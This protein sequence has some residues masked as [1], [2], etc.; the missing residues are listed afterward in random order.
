MDRMFLL[1]ALLIAVAALTP[2][3]CQTVPAVVPALAVGGQG[4]LP[5]VL[6]VPTD[7]AAP[8]GFVVLAKTA[9]TNVTG[10]IVSGGNVGLSP[11]SASYLTGF[12][13]VADDSGA[14]ATSAAVES[15]G[16]VFAA[17]NAAPT[18]GALT[19]AILAMEAAYADAA[20]RSPPD[21][22]N[23]GGGALGG[24]TLAPGLYTW[25][26]SVAIARDLTLAGGADDVWIL[27][28]AGDLTLAPHLRVL[29]SGGARARNVYWQVA[30]ATRI[31]TGAD[32]LGI[33]LCKTSITFETNA[34]L[35]GRAFAQS[36]I[37]LDNN[38][39]TA[40]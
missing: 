5:I 36:Q 31:Q 22:L 8:S 1:P 7:V 14:F 35:S 33:V 30:G 21:F 29:L 34:S 23:L 27:Q 10:S 25:G 19:A 12:A 38:V 11:A 39:I 20:G 9:V 24:L 6:G 13:L 32:F 2:S 3:A 16:R 26:S 15:P 4:P 28:I 18:P 17:D 37:A 40:P